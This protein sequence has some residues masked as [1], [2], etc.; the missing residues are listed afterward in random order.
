V[1]SIVRTV[2]YLIVKKAIEKKR[3]EA[4]RWS[5]AALDDYDEAQNK[6]SG[7]KEG[8]QGGFECGPRNGEELLFVDQSTVDNPAAKPTAMPGTPETT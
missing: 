6:F 2:R 1:Y 4:P 8:D 7:R 5:K 3:K